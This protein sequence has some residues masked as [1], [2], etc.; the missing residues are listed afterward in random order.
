MLQNFTYYAQFMLQICYALCSTNLTF[1]FSYPTYVNYKI[2]SISCF[3]SSPAVQYTIKISSMYVYKHFEFIF[4][5][6]AT[7]FNTH[8]DKI[9]TTDSP[10]PHYPVKKVHVI[11]IVSIVLAMVVYYAGIMLNDFTFLLCSKYYYA[12]IIGSSLKLIPPK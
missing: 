11:Q 12:G 9:I 6:F 7:L 3:S 4:V 5:E 8:Y 10:K 2:T 1:Y